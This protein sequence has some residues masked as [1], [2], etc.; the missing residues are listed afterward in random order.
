MAIF[1]G[2]T[3]DQFIAEYGKLVRAGNGS[4]Q[5]AY[6]FGS[7]VNALHGLYT[8]KQLGGVIDRTGGMVAIYAKLAR[9]YPNE[10][11]LLRTADQL[12]TYDISRLAGGTPSA[13]A[14]YVML[15]NHCGTIG[16]VSRHKESVARFLVEQ[17]QKQDEPALS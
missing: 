17:R 6:R 14:T 1:A 3:L 11:A 7:V 16:E 4:L 8:Y 15:C 5:A 10:N 9:S 2:E 13:S 12:Q